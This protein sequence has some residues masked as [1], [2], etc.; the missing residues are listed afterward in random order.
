MSVLRKTLV[1]GVALCWGGVAHATTMRPE[2]GV[3][4]QQAGQA[5]SAH[6][7]SEA[8][9]DVAKAQAVPGKSASE[10][11]TIN[12]MKAAI[13]TTSGNREA[14]ASDYANL[15]ASGM[16]SGDELSRIIQAEASSYYEAGD[17][18][19][20]ATVIRAH[21]MND[22][23]YHQLLLQSYLKTGDC[24]QLSSAVGA[25]GTQAD[26][27]LVAYCFA[28]GKDHSAYVQALINNVHA[29]PTPANWAQL[30][31]V[32][33]ANPVYS[34]RLALD[35]FRVQYAAGVKLTASD[36]MQAI[37]EALQAGQNNEAE[38][39]ITKA[40]A[41]KILGQGPDASRQD[42][43]KK[44][45]DQRVADQ[46][47]DM[48]QAAKQAETSHDELTLFNIGFNKVQGGDKQGLAMMEAAIASGGLV[49]I[50]QAKLELGLAYK[51]AGE[52]AKALAT[53]HSVT[54]TDGSADLANL[55]I[56]MQ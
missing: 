54:G 16:L 4:L 17:Y 22:P 49:Q 27:N 2:V 1:L 5:L 38:K 55:W 51:A 48:V 56:S 47:T 33:Q 52:T 35:F 23:R 9:E 13:D 44:L 28:T 6:R 26:M 10:I 11:F 43:L 29:Y 24:K 7:Y 14:A 37:Q 3:P 46:A 31:G 41:D 53:W 15:Q 50:P 8:L 40:Y 39:I 25:H 18:A 45:V 30:L 12:E 19:H 32:M 36:Y 21:L 42:R 20:A 34:D